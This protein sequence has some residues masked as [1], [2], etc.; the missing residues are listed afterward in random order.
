MTWFRT[1]TM[2]AFLI[3]LSA[4]LWQ[5]RPAESQPLT[6]TVEIRFDCDNVPWPCTG[7]SL[8]NRWQLYRVRCD[9]GGCQWQWA[10]R[11]NPGTT[12][13]IQGFEQYRMYIG[14]DGDSDEIYDCGTTLKSD[15]ERAV[16]EWFHRCDRWRDVC[17]GERHWQVYTCR[18]KDGACPWV[19]AKEIT[20]D[21]TWLHMRL[22]Q[23]K[24][25]LLHWGLPRELDETSPTPT[26]TGTPTPTSTPSP[27]RTQPPSATPTETPGATATGEPEESTV[28]LPVVER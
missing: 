18:E 20:T 10:Q 12:Q 25:F 6:S 1:A 17:R 3:G 23:G 21:C 9:A 5:A 15:A 27:T 22:E 8:T 14:P 7:G 16:W 11:V 2:L 19:W 13:E 28:Y 24:R 26:P 4:A